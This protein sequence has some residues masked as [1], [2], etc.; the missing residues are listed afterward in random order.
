MLH[1]NLSPLEP[2]YAPGHTLLIV[3]PSSIPFVLMV[4]PQNF[5]LPLTLTRPML[6]PLSMLPF[7]INPSALLTTLMV[8]TNKLS[9]QLLILSYLLDLHRSLIDPFFLLPPYVSSILSP[10]L[11]P[12]VSDLLLPYVSACPLWACY[13]SC[14]V[15]RLCLLLYIRAPLRH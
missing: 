11:S 15:M 3:L 4:F 10:L 1:P 12:C 9:S 5:G 8:V 6:T 14:L 13:C 7:A 2:F